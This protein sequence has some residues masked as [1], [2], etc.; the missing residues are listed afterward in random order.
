MTA[1]T[2]IP[3][4]DERSRD[5]EVE[6]VARTLGDAVVVQTRVRDGGAGC[7]KLLLKERL[8]VQNDDL[9]D[10]PECLVRDLGAFLDLSTLQQAVS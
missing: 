6:Y 7:G 4:R 8:P 9:P 3:R 5:K 1:N 2:P 10:R